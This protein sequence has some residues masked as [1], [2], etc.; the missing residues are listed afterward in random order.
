MADRIRFIGVRALLGNGCLHAGGVR[1]IVYAHGL[2]ALRRL[3]QGPY[4]ARLDN[5][6]FGL[7]PSK[8][9]L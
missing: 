4:G 1:L 7:R 2:N 5:G 9:A 3:L 8:L 6:G